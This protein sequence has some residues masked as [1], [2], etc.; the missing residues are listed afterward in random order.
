M[1]YSDR[2]DHLADLMASQLRARGTTLTQVARSAG[3]RLPRRLHRDVDIVAEAA[4][5]S[6]HPKLRR[7]IDDRSFARSE[8]RL[9]SY[10]GD[11]NPGSERR[12][13]FLDR[14]AAVAF[15]F[16]VVAL[17]LFFWMLST[18]RL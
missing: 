9:A 12:D 5:L 6:G 18:G 1:S 14:L 16:C 7:M 8:R 13:E 15:I 3:R 2:A 4:Q 10:L 17:S 11:Q